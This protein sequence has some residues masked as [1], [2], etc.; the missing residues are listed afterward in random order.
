[1][2]LP[3][4][5]L[6]FLVVLSVL[7]F[8][9]ELGH[10]VTAKMAGIKVQEFGFGYPPRV[11]GIK[12]GETIY[13]LNLLPL[14]GFVRMLGEN[15]KPG[16][17]EAFAS[18]PRG[19]RAL[20]LI[21][22]SAMNLALA[23][24]LYSS[25]FM[26]GIHQECDTCNRVQIY[27]VRPGT[28]A[29]QAGLRTDDVFLRIA[30]RPVSTADEVRQLVRTRGGQ[31]TEVVVERQGSPLTLRLT[32][33]SVSDEREPAIGVSLGNEMVTVRYPVWQAVPM[34]FQH[35]GNVIRIF[36]DGMQRMLRRE[37]DAELQGPVGIARETGRAA[38]AG[39]TYLLQ[40]TAFLSLNLAI[41]N[42]LP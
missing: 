22:G 8:A 10:F 34:G 42:M 23:P 15:G 35:T 2:S 9:H 3:Q 21:A 39:L 1:M 4:T 30:G 14:G 31:D 18:K 28:P 33:R 37:V 7:V 16:D 12:R 32:P 11:F 41:F 38:E 5:A 36:A 6:L 27:D 25:A 24:L 17:P 20:V 40:F 26:V 13:S 19:V 29:D